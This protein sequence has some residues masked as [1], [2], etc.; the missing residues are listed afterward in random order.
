METHLMMTLHRHS[1]EHMRT[2]EEIK[3]LNRKGVN[4]LAVLKELFLVSAHTKA[5]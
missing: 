4:V 2:L 5:L 1:P 3:A